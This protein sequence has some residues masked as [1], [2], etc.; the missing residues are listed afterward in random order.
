[1]KKAFFAFAMVAAL[2]LTACG[3][4]KPNMDD[5]KSIAEFNCKKMKEMMDLMKDPVAN[6]GKIEGISKEMEDFEKEFKEH[7]GAKSE[8][9]EKKVEESL[10][11][12]CAD[13]ANA[14]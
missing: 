3:G 7:H 4:G 11:V 14:F 1:M 10:A 2:M 9:M 12:V 5:P 8:E 6:A 13:L